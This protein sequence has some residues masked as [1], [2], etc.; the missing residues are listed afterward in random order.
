ML[1]SWWI[2]GTTSQVQHVAKPASRLFLEVC[3]MGAYAA[4]V[5][6]G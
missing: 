4:G 1:D 5:A 3:W 6:T 2:S